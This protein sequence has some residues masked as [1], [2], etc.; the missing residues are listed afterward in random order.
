MDEKFMIFLGDVL[1]AATQSQKQLKIMFD[2][3]NQGL[4]GHDDLTTFFKKAYG[5]ESPRDSATAD[6]RNWQQASADFQKSFNQYMGMLGVVSK[7]E[8]L[9]LKQKYEALQ[10]KAGRQEETITRLEK[11]LAQG[12]GAQAELARGFSDL[13]AEQTRQ[14][15]TAMASFGQL[16]KGPGKK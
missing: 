4:R 2:W 8:H 7:K 11:L 12:G 9:E 13:M 6:N 1:N 15:E 16:F 14:F 3:V 5:L 10:K